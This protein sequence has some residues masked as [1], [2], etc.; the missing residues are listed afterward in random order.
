MYGFQFDMRFER[1]TKIHFFSK[2]LTTHFVVSFCILPFASSAGQESTFGDSFDLGPYGIR[3]LC[4]AEQHSCMSGFDPLLFFEI[5]IIPEGVFDNRYEKPV[6]EELPVAIEIIEYFLESDQP[7]ESEI[8][9]GPS[10]LFEEVSE[11]ILFV[12]RLY[13]WSETKCL[14]PTPVG[15]NDFAGKRFA[16][17]PQGKQTVVYPIIRKRPYEC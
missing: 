2:K 3:N 8:V 12:I 16:G 1:D 15:R 7:C 13:R 14:P 17:Y 4:I 6:F 10:C 5:K 9:V 11:Q